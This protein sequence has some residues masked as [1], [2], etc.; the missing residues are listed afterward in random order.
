MLRAAIFGILHTFEMA[1]IDDTDGRAA[2]VEYFRLPRLVAL[3]ECDYSGSRNRSN[4]L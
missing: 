1:T 2:A 4:H 3:G